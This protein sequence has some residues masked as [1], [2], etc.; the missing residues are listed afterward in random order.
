MKSNLSEED[1]NNIIE[2]YKAGTSAQALYKEY[3][4][5]ERTLNKIFKDNNVTKRTVLEAVRLNHPWKKKNKFVSKPCEKLKQ[6]LIE[7]NIDIIEEY[8]NFDRKFKIDIYLPKYNIGLEVNGNQHYN[9]DG[10]LGDYYQERHDYII[11]QGIELI[12]LH[13]LV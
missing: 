13:Y 5:S 9:K 11:N 4:T 12:E 1:I 2:K 8:N 10:T 3:R 6:M 7:N